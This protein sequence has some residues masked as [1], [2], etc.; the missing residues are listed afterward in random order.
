[1]VCSYSVAPS[2]RCTHTW[3]TFTAEFCLLEQ[4][5]PDGLDHPFA[6]TMLS[7]FEKLNTPIKSVDTYSTLAQQ[8][9][10]FASRGWKTVDTWTLWQAWANS[11]FLSADDRR[12]LDAVEP[13]DEWEEFALFGSHYCL[14]H[15]ST[16]DSTSAP[17]EFVAAKAT[18]TSPAPADIPTKG[19]RLQCHEGTGKKVQ[20]RF[21]A[22]KR[23]RS[24]DDPW[25]SDTEFLLNFMGLGATSR[26]ESYDVFGPEK[27][28]HGLSDL[29]TGPASRMCHTL[30][31]HASDS[32][33]LVGGRGAPSNPLKDCWSLDGSSWTR[34]KD[35]PRPLYRHSAA[36][37]RY[38]DGESPPMVLIIGGKDGASSVFDGAY[39]F[40]NLPGRG[41]SR[42]LSCKIVGED[43]TPVSGAFLVS[44]PRPKGSHFSGI[45]GGGIKDDGVLSEKLYTWSLDISDYEV[46]TKL[47]PL[48][49]SE[50]Y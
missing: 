25:G 20:R 46:S 37:L 6:K 2:V 36:S 33:L 9:D 40:Y 4:I 14:V 1:M 12:K 15:A 47:S 11:R 28:E 16:M 27:T 30:T 44:I 8:R 19:I 45:Y 39:F 13:F 48:F 32:S 22:S 26:L 34:E 42:W 18:Q 38:S 21:G 50:N 23:I 17:T 43:I 41:V 49:L 5:L 31:H 35:L 7:H 3:L 10:R 29:G 24:Y